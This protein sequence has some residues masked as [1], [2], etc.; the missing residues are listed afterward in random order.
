MKMKKSKNMLIAILLIVF[1]LV[2]IVYFSILGG[3]HDRKTVTF[4]T[5]PQAAEYIEKG[6]IPGNIPENAKNIILY[7][8]I[9]TNV[10]N[11]SFQSTQEY[12][13]KFKE[14]LHESEKDEFI[15][16]KR[17]IHPKFKNITESFLKRDV[18]FYKNESYLFVIEEHTIYFF[19][20]HP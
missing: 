4:S 11:G 8:D 6:W 15:H 5:K 1:V 3:F 19:S 20:L 12:I 9:D 16:K 18:S 14:S 17:I 2:I 7:Y 10:V 13:S